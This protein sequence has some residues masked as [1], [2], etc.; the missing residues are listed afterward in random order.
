MQRCRGGEEM[1]CCGAEVVVERWWRGAD[2]VQRCWYRS[3]ADEVVL[4][5]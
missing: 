1:R 3:G 4:R 2:V 5:W